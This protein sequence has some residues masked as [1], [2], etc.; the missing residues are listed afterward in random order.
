[1]TIA[2]M[3][4]YFLPYIGYWQLINAVNLF[5]IFDDVSFINKSFINHN[6]I[7]INCKKQ[8]FTLELI[9]ASQNKII[10]TIM[11]GNNQ[12]KLLKTIK[13]AYQKAP[14]FINIF[15]IIEKILLQEEKNLSKFIRFSLEEISTY[16]GMDTQFIYSSDVN[17][18][19]DLKAQNKIIEIC[20][21]LKATNYINP[22]GGQE[23]YNKKVF[24]YENITL[25]FL[26]TDFIEYKQFKNEFI[27]HLSIIDILMFNS[28]DKIKNMLEKYTLI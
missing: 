7:L 23:L 15:P 2:I 17:K 13:M 1:M 6:N 10:N 19:N 5:V 3:Q 9:K 26:K 8:Q 24:E 28:I 21:K 18:N 22:I 12:E 16:L 4:P 20:K 27:P 14:Y 25:N 11:I